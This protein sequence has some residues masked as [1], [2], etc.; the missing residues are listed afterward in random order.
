MR[1]I[2]Y[3]KAIEN[4]EALKKLGQGVV[5][6]PQGDDYPW[7]LA[8]HCEP[9]GVYRNGIPVSA[10]ITAE[11]QDSGLTFRWAFDIEHPSANGKSVFEIDMEG[12]RQALQAMPIAHRNSM[13]Q[14]FES[15]AAAV[16]ARGE[17]FQKAADDQ[18]RAAANLSEL[19]CMD[20]SRA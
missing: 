11:D 10:W 16:R 6:L 14:W 18:K 5:F 7:H 17:E 12:C 4:A 1:D 19:A 2:T 8:T 15:T 3:K 13:R 20:F 9:C